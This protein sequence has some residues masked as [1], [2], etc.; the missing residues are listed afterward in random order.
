MIA[1]NTSHFHNFTKKNSF[2]YLKDYL[3]TK[4]NPSG[5]KVYTTSI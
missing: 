3:M 1:F 4:L 2:H 5:N